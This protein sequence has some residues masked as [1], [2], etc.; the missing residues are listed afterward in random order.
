MRIVNS[1]FINDITYDLED[2]VQA[3]MYSTEILFS[4]SMTMAHG[5]SDEEFYEKIKGTCDE[6]ADKKTKK[7]IKKAVKFYKDGVTNHFKNIL[8]LLRITDVQDKKSQR[9]KPKLTTKVN[10]R[11]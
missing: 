7:E 5:L 3:A 11:K 4:S 8:G 9:M 2:R 10:M 1:V 6:V